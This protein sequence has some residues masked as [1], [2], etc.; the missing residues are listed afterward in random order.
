M[1]HQGNF[2][3]ALDLLSA[4]LRDYCTDHNLPQKS[5]DE[6]LAD[7]LLQDAEEDSDEAVEIPRH[8]DYLSAFVARWE[9]TEN[10]DKLLLQCDG[11]VTIDHLSE[12]EQDDFVGLHQSNNLK[13]V[14][15]NIAVTM[16]RRGSESVLALTW[17]EARA[18][19]EAL[20]KMADI[21]EH[22]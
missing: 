18:L 6:L 20:I 15:P 14:I 4:E 17:D 12:D 10:D 8:I 19:G 1:N 11:V 7:L 9:A 21:C 3:S 5:A 16:V 13:S 2:E 22:G